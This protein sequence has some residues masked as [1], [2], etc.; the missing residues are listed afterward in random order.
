MYLSHTE[1]LR[2]S[3][4]VAPSVWQAGCGGV[5][6]VFSGAGAMSWAHATRAAAPRSACVTAPDA[7]AGAELARRP[8]APYRCRCRCSCRCCC[9]RLCEPVARRP[10]P[11]RQPHQQLPGAPPQR[12]A[13]TRPGA[14][15][16]VEVRMCVRAR[17]AHLVCRRR[18]AKRNVIQQLGAAVVRRSQRLAQRLAGIG[19]STN[20]RCVRLLCIAWVARRR[21]Q[22]GG[23]RCHWAAASRWRALAVR[24]AL[25]VGGAQAQ[26]PRVCNREPVAKVPMAIQ[27]PPG[28]C[29]RPAERRTRRSGDHNL[30]PAT[31]AGGLSAKRPKYV[32]LPWR[33]GCHPVLPPRAAAPNTHQA[34]RQRQHQQCGDPHCCVLCNFQLVRRAGGRWAAPDLGPA[35]LPPFGLLRHPGCSRR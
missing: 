3:L 26:A 32:L 1:G 8:V 35:P 17:R 19:R 2:P 20:Q 31:W 16:C 12:A 27:A 7:D 28:A 24:G 25:A 14:A 10:L 6:V 29:P 23:A 13:R 33:W 22:S 5:A 4:S 9:H 34:G 15:A 30:F 21:G 11:A 18:D